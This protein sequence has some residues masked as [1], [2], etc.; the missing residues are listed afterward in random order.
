MDERLAPVAGESAKID[1]FTTNATRREASDSWAAFPNTRQ[2]VLECIVKNKIQNV[3]FLSGDIHCANVAEISFDG[4]AA[5]KKLK[6][7]NV[8]SSA[9]YWPFPFAVGDPNAYVHDSRK[10]EQSDPFP[11]GNTG[12]TMHYRSYGYTQEDNFCRLDLDKAS[13]SLT[14][15][16]FDRKGKPIEVADFAGAKK[17]G[18][19]LDLAAW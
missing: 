17:M 1:L 3:V 5:A 12:A 19:V 15:R 11:V 2:A 10:K 14:V 4:P 6:A 16:I 18:S 9:F 8:T 7:F 13:H